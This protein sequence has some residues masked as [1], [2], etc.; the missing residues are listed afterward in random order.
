VSDVLGLPPR[1]QNVRL[2]WC[3]SGGEIERSPPT[4]LPWSCPAGARSGEYGGLIWRVVSSN[5]VCGDLRSQHAHPQYPIDCFSIEHL[6]EGTRNAPWGWQ[7]NAETCRSY[8]TSL[9]N[10][11]NN[12]CLFWF[13]KH[14]F[15][16]DFNF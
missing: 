9:I 6:S 11:M 1:L 2:S 8:R 12:W 15:T 10:W 16:G 4:V 14:I 3:S 7:Y 5:V 13:F